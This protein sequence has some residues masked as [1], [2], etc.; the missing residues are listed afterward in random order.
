MD[1]LYELRAGRLRGSRRL[2]L[3]C[4]LEEFPREIFDLADTLEVLN[5][6]DNKLRTLPDDLGRLHGLRILFCSNNR[7]EHLPEALGSC[8]SLSMVGFK[9]NCIERVAEGALPSSLRW[10]ILT[11]NRIEHL[12]ASLGR[13][14]GLQKLMLSGNRLRELPAGLAA[15]EKLELLRLAANDMHD[16]PSWLLTL[17]RL[18]WLALAG[19]PCAPS[20]RLEGV[21]TAGVN[22]HDLELT[23]PLGEGASGFIHRARLKAGCEGAGR[24]VAV[25]V[26]KGAMTSDGLPE[27]ELAASLTAGNHPHLIEVLGRIDQHPAGSPGL[28]MALVDPEFESLAAPPS[29]D[30]CTRDIYAE[31]RRF[32]PRAVLR[33]AFGIASAAE[34]LHRHGIMHGDLYAHNILSNAGGESL[35]GDFGAASF[36]PEDHARALQQIEVRAFGCLLEE[37]L[38]RT[39]FPLGEPTGGLLRSLQARCLDVDRAARPFFAEI[40][41]ELTACL[42]GG[43]IA[44]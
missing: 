39:V 20:P 3:S 6:T 34:H 36:C 9:A 42:V 8:A 2:D 41:D 11:D 18:A 15:C 14:A 28:V 17:P 19:N 31:G 30:T 10:L 16:L 12:P 26:F 44:G 33:L 32:D 38:D 4:G 13:C 40:C 21:R 5:L 29:W 22:W 7:F 23:A 37:L 24:E 25:K 1:T 27:C 35:L 43:P